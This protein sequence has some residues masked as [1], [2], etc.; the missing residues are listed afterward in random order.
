MRDEIKRNVARAAAEKRLHHYRNCERRNEIIQYAK[1]LNRPDVPQE[2][3]DET[4]HVLAW[5]TREFEHRFGVRKTNYE[6]IY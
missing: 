3:A 4:T 5:T 1:L 6:I 2:S